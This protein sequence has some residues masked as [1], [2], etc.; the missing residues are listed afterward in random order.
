MTKMDKFDKRGNCNRQCDHGMHQDRHC[1]CYDDI[2]RVPTCNVQCIEKPEIKPGLVVFGKAVPPHG[3]VVCGLQ[4]RQHYPIVAKGLVYRNANGDKVWDHSRCH[5]DVY[6]QND[7]HFTGT[8][9]QDGSFRLLADSRSDFKDILGRQFIIGMQVGYYTYYYQ[10]EGHI[11]C[12]SGPG[13]FTDLYDGASHI[14]IREM[15]PIWTTRPQ[16]CSV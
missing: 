7:F 10:I 4:T 14:V 9:K 11:E 16:E 2:P 1:D 15:P 8:L 12:V 3:P 5:T 6:W 13:A